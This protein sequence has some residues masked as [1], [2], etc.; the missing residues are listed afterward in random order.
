M[1][2]VLD[3]F[4]QNQGRTHLEALRDLDVQLSAHPTP[5]GRAWTASVTWWR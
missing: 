3:L 2:L 1:T 4:H 5:G